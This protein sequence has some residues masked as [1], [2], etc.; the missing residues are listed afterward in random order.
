MPFVVT[1]CAFKIHW[2]RGPGRGQPHTYTLRMCTANWWVGPCNSVRDRASFSLSNAVVSAKSRQTDR[3]TDWHTH[4]PS[5]VTIAAHARW[6]LITCC[7]GTG[8]LPR[9]IGAQWRMCIQSSISLNTTYCCY[10][11]AQRSVNGMWP[12]SII[13]RMCIVHFHAT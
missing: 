4:R 11:V 8:L 9:L 10:D 13:M 2:A 3:Q 12:G 7:N 1:S 5:T 6:G